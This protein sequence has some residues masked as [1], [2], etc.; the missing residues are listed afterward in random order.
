LRFERPGITGTIADSRSRFR[1][2]LASSPCRKEISRTLQSSQQIWR[3][4]A[5]CRIA[6]CRYERKG[7]QITSASTG[8][9]SIS[10]ILIFKRSILDFQLVIAV[11]ADGH[12]NSAAVALYPRLVRQCVAHVFSDAQVVL[13]VDPDH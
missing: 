11:V 10:R 5:I 1:R 4:R 9:V 7:Q 2:L 12:E 8:F 13:V 6:T 3:D